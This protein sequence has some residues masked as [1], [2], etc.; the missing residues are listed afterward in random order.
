MTSKEA[1]NCVRLLSDVFFLVRISDPDTNDVFD[2][3]ENG[4]FVPITTC[5]HVWGRS[6]PCIHC[7][8]LR[9][10]HQRIT[11]DKYEVKDND[12]FHVTSKPVDI[13][14]HIYA[15]EIVTKLDNS[16]E[17]TKRILYLEQESETLDAQRKAA[18][19]A[20]RAKTSF[21][22]NM[23]HDI[24]TPMNA[25]IGFNEMALKHL[26]EPE[27]VK[28]CLKKVNMSS[29]H[30]LSIINDVLDMARIESGKVTIEEAPVSMT[31]S[32][33]ELRDIVTQNVKDKNLTMITDFSHITHDLVLTDKL[34]LTRVMMNLISN[35]IKYTNPGGTVSYTVT[36]KAYSNDGIASYEFV[37]A[38]NGIGMSP[39]FLEHVF[40]AF[41][42][43]KTSTVSGIQGTGLGMAITK[44]LVDLLG[45]TISIAS[46]QGKGTTA[47]VN[48]AFKILNEQDTPSN[49][50]KNIVNTMDLNGKRVLLAE[51]NELNREITT[52]ILEESGMLVV[53]AEN[54]QA[55]VE[56]YLN[57]ISSNEPFDVILMDVQMPVL[58][59]YEATAKIRK[60][61]VPLHRHIPVIATTAN[62]YA[63]DISNCKKAGMDGHIAKPIDVQKLLN[64]LL[65]I[66]G[67]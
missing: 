64:T 35:S 30:L 23:S 38:D 44:E 40:E 57:S 6:T 15:L 51:D 60:A 58:D 33:E 39:E 14:G 67:R 55:A 61:E 18:D 43:E 31:K 63:E 50:E 45:G 34:R 2:L 24:R 59:G 65:E 5:Y 36:E 8:T 56:K 29:H 37:V 13:D 32:A 22:F 19:V 16:K 53:P 49:D 12:V 27:R 3:N 28:D 21:L 42:R 62:A 7:S 46:E 9:T 54:G 47:T 20:S 48:F 11:T 66:M 41:S 10:C 25:I 4:E 1:V 52:E 17:L 26:D